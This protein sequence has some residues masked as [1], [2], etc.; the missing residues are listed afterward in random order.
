M[1]I[2]FDF[3]SDEA[4]RAMQDV[5]RESDR[6]DKEII[7]M[8]SRTLVRSVAF[9]T[10]KDTGTTRAGWWPAWNALEMNGSPG[11]RRNYADW[12]RRSGREMVPEGDVEDNRRG[13]GEKSFAFSN[14]THYIDKRGKR[15]NY[16]YIL[17]AQMGWMDK[18]NEEVEFK[19]GR[20]YE[21]LLKKH[22][23]I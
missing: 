13:R 6:S 3:M 10:P 12:K 7:D 18:A 1:D 8:N 21:K 2:G 23:K 15:V 9:N 19:F 11:T 14:S 5:I 22:S 17:N 20:T 4:E 16:P